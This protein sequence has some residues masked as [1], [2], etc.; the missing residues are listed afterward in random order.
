ML[1]EPE[2]L[3]IVRNV[4]Y[5]GNGKINY[6]EFLAAT[7]ELKKVLTYDR[8]WALFKYFDTDNSGYITPANLREAFAKSG[9][10]LTKEEMSQILELHDLEKNG[11]LSFDE[12]RQIFFTKESKDNM[13]AFATADSES[14]IN[15][16]QRLRLNKKSSPS[17]LKGINLQDCEQVVDPSDWENAQQMNS[18]VSKQSRSLKRRVVPPP[19]TQEEVDFKDNKI[20]RGDSKT[21][22]GKNRGRSQQP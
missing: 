18:P 4:D 1:S 8:L 13:H 2:L 7:V 5:A 16:M 21:G 19:T 22:S 3:D 12:F 10:M 11:I 15:S 14:P 6:S 20:V 9:K 17:A